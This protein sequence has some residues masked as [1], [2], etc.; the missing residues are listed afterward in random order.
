MKRAPDLRLA[1]LLAAAC[2]LICAIVPDGATVVRVLP[3]ALLVLVLPGY[4]LT[5][6][7][8]APAQVTRLER[9]VL[10][11]ALSMV[12]GVLTALVLNAVWHLETA[13][14][15]TGL[16]L[17]TIVAALAGARRGHGQP[18]PRPRVPR[19]GVAAALALIGAVLLTGGAVALGVTT[20][21]APG[22]TAGT[23]ALWISPRGDNN[24]AVGVHSIERGRRHYELD[25]RVA[26]QR[27]RLIGPFALEP[28]EERRLALPAPAGP[29]G[30]PVVNVVLRR[31]DGP[32]PAI[33]HVAL[34][35]GRRSV[36]FRGPPPARPCPRAHP[37]RSANGCY[38]VVVRGT[39]RLRKYANGRTVVLR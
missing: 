7:L 5:A 4:A 25:V 9:L 38:R 39:K 2:A 26:G 33:R 30:K 15:A 10:T 23:T 18:V 16:A 11:I 35:A 34:R 12:A 8:L 1:A 27:G 19:V 22:D 24:V 6:T 21:H 28:G 31:L 29:L 14:W 36:I 20:L 37:L 32:H 17:A 3:A 13:A